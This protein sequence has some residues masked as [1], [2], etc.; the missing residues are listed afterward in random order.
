MT[1]VKSYTRTVNGQVQHVEAYSRTQGSG[2][3][4]DGQRMNRAQREF[5]LVLTKRAQRGDEKAAARL[6]KLNAA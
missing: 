2:Y 3:T 5:L 4:R 6:A 1:N